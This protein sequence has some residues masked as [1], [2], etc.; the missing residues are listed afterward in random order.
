MIL[1]VILD[2]DNINEIISN[3]D[4]DNDQFHAPS[5]RVFR[6]VARSGNQ[7][8]NKCQTRVYIYI[9]IYIERE[10]DI[11]IYRERERD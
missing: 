6:P 2:N 8:G 4:N 3:T 9:Y 11:D 7:G 10:R 1:L 5:R